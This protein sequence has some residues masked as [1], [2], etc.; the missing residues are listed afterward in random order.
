MTMH[1]T[2]HAWA[3][4]KPLFFEEEMVIWVLAFQSNEKKHI[5]LP[6]LPSEYRVNPLVERRKEAW[7]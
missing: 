2:V 6:A 3:L 7:S 4:R 5:L 1:R